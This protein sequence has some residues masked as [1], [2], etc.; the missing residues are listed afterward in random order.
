MPPRCGLR[1]SARPNREA[2][3]GPTATEVA[4]QLLTEATTTLGWKSSRAMLAPQEEAVLRYVMIQYPLRGRSPSREEIG[5]ALSIGNPDEVQAALGRL[6]K[7]DLLCLDPESREV[8]CAYP[9]STEPTKHV[10]RFLDWPDAKPVYALCAVDALGVPF[11]FHRDVSVTSSCPHCARPIT[12]KVR[13]GVIVD[14]TPAETVVWRGTACS[15]HAATSLCPA[16]NFFCSWDHAA[17]W[18]QGHPH[19][20]GAILDLGEVLYLGKGLFED[21]LVSSSGSQTPTDAATLTSA[22]GLVAALL[23]SICCVGPLVFAALGVGIGATGFLAGTAGFLKALLPYRPVFIGLT[24]LLLGI[25]FYL[26][27]RKHGVTCAPGSR[28]A[29]SNSLWTPRALLWIVAGIALALILASY[30]LGL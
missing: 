22:G 1:A 12:I 11:M 8:C 2:M 25:S 9:F 30:W 10:V 14:R 5:V 23:A 24:V 17:I 4:T 6:E 7:A 20:T 29:P 3:I 27:Y 21:H 16:V 26:A 18:R 13:N 15:E 28:C 19:L